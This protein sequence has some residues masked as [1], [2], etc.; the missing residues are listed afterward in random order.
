LLPP[1][2]LPAVVL[3][4]AG[5]LAVVL[6]P[7]LVCGL[8][9]VLPGI[10]PSTTVGGMVVATPSAPIATAGTPTPGL[11]CCFCFLLVV[12]RAFRV[13]DA[14]AAITAFCTLVFAVLAFAGVNPKSA[15]CALWFPKYAM[16]AFFN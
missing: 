9:L 6:L 1:A 5:A 14:F 11:I 4:A 8:V 10:A 13:R 15:N 2:P 7:A 12:P 16:T 3:P